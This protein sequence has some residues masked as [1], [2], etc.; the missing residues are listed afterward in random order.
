MVQG[1][2]PDH[3]PALL[4]PRWHAGQPEK[5]FWSPTKAP[6]SEGLPIGAFRCKDCGFLE[7]Y[8]DLKFAAQ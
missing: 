6:I 4:V 2:V 3:S 7:S 8:S 1:F 5:S